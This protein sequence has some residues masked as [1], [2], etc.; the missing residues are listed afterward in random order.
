MNINFPDLEKLIK[1]AERSNINSLEV[2]DGDARIFI[3]CRS[4]GNESI[5]GDNNNNN[6]RNLA[7]TSGSKQRANISAESNQ[8]D[9]GN[10]DAVLN[11]KEAN[12]DAQKQVTAPMLGTF[13]RRSEPTADEFVK[14]GDKVDKGQTLCIIEAMKMMH[15][16]KAEFPCTIKE[17]L[18]D[19]GDVVEYGQPLFIIEPTS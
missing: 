19:E 3:I 16:V 1:I 6:K 14:V 18:V 7:S 10:D 8:N 4:D 12:E 17:A 11:K 9:V 2:T 13:Y 15:E 5:S